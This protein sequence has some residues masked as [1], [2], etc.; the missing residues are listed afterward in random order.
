MTKGAPCIQERKNKIKKIQHD[1]R[2][3]MHADKKEKIKKSQHDERG[4]T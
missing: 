2:G 4:A 3:A 1:E